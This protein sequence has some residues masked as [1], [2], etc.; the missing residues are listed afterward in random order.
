MPSHRVVHLFFLRFHLHGCLSLP[1]PHDLFLQ[2]YKWF[3][4]TWL[5]CHHWGGG[6]E[7]M[8]SE[9]RKDKSLRGVPCPTQPYSKCSLYWWRCKCFN[10]TPAGKNVHHSMIALCAAKHV[11]KKLLW[12]S[13]TVK[14][15]HK[16][17]KHHTLHIPP[18]HTWSWG[19]ISSSLW[20]D[21]SRNEI[22]VNNK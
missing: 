11:F 18:L 22:S 4:W 3:L 1:Q 19:T 14:I 8:K 5:W 2:A 17:G 7:Q 21:V 12:C 20:M 13:G 16:C 6:D 9:E 15:S 10:V